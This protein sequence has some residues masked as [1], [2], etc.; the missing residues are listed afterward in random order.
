MSGKV[1]NRFISFEVDDSTTFLTDGFENFYGIKSLYSKIENKT[2]NQSLK[3]NLIQPE[4]MYQLLNEYDTNERNLDFFIN[5]PQ[6]FRFIFSTAINLPQYFTYQEDNGFINSDELELNE[7]GYHEIPVRFKGLSNET[8]VYDIN[9]GFESSVFNANF[10]IAKGVNTILYS[11]NMSG[12]HQWYI[13]GELFSEL[14]SGSINLND[15]VYKLTHVLT[16]D[17]NN[18]C[19]SSTIINVYMNSL[20][21]ELSVEKCETLSLF[22]N[23]ET[24]FIEYQLDGVKYSSKN[25]LENFDQDFKITAINYFRATPTSPISFKFTVNFD[26][27]LYNETM[28]QKI[29]LKDF[30]GTFKYIIL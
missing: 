9:Y 3:I 25:T 27:T 23:F 26:A 1:D 28:T 8:F 16:D 15:G 14:G 20:A 5:Q 12:K 24:V 6:C 18:S 22:N 30:E 17:M 21:W 11:A 13:D 19:S 2:L 4:R 10:N 7:K 29:E